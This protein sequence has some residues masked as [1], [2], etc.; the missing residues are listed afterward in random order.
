MRP[1]KRAVLGVL[2]C[3]AATGCGALGDFS[4]LP[5]SEGVTTVRFR[6]P[7]AQL[8]LASGVSAMSMLT[9]GIFIYINGIDGT[10]FNGTFVIPDEN[11]AGSLFLP[12]GAYRISAVAWS[13][14]PFQGPI[15]CGF[16]D[17]GAKIQLT[18]GTR[19]ID[20]T[21]SQALC[22]PTIAPDYFAPAAWGSSGQIYPLEVVTCAP[23]AFSGI[24][25]SGSGACSST[26]IGRIRSMRIELVNYKS[27]GYNWKELPSFS[28]PCFDGGGGVYALTTSY[29]LP[30]GNTRRDPKFATR[31]VTFDATGCE[32]GAAPTPTGTYFFPSG[33][34]NTD[35][36][37]V[38]GSG[39]G[40]IGASPAKA[41][42]NGTNIQLFLRDA[43]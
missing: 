41:Y 24:S 15:Y 22:S 36:A 31:I 4:R 40:A 6:G 12:N 28:S 2:L 21:M 7:A 17:A 30:M 14:L 8:D 3:F 9:G 32:Q 23:S 38:N 13:S 39:I 10:P 43:Q 33:I 16:G 1:L 20:L 26:N 29:L 27:D 11:V 18:G 19:T 5:S 25:G 35:T 37:S 34:F 42:S